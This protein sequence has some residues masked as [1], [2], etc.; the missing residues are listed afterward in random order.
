MNNGRLI[1][2]GG[3]GFLGTLLAQQAA[4]RGWEVV[5]LSR[6]PSPCGGAVREVFW[7][8]HTLG[9][10]AELFEGA[11]AVVNLA[12]RNV[13]CRFTPENLREI[14]ESRVNSVRAVAAAIRQCAQPPQVFVQAA[15]QAIYGDLGDRRCEESTPPGEG[16]LAPTC[17]L[18][19]SAFEESPTPGVRR[20]L[21]RI[22]FVLDRQGGAL[23]PLAALAKWGLGGQT[24]SGR[25][26]ISWI[27]STDMCRIFQFAIERPEAQG[28]FNACAPNPVSNA[29]F[30]RALRHALH[31][32]WSPPVPAWAVRI[33]ARLI[34]TEPRLALTGCRCAPKRLLEAGFDFSFRDIEPALEDFFKSTKPELGKPQRI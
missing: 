10:W 34:G 14:D 6:R 3:S 30:M 15:G 2:A 18:W 16:F 29:H 27:H 25:Q 5:V 24:G 28:V 26:Y 9:S 31:R 20:V 8:G 19:E 13:N 1:L 17:R 11:S 12:G 32:P 21:L 23:K 22:G 4:A 33:G 7:D